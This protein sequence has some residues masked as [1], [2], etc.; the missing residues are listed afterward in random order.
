M[1]TNGWKNKAVVAW[2]AVAILVV[3]AIVTSLSLSSA[4]TKKT[5]DDTGNGVD[6]AAVVKLLT[7][8]SVTEQCATRTNQHLVKYDVGALKGTP[9]AA[10]VSEAKAE[11]ERVKAD[12]AANANGE[13]NR[14]MRENATGAESPAGKIDGGK[15]P[16]KPRAK[17][18]P[19]PEGAS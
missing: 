5:A 7:V 4:S 15:A 11:A 13:P 19:P 17:K 14:A 9:P 2:C 3:V 16:R 12:D 10:K 1:T 8:T 18:T 6:H